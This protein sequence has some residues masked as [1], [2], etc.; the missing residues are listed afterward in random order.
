MRRDTS[1]D[2][3]GYCGGNHI[4]KFCPKTW[5][6]QLNLRVRFCSY[7]GSTGHEYQECPKTW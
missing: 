3:C 1:H 7:C 2:Y 4:E 6:G 5:C